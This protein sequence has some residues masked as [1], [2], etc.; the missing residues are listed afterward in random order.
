[1]QIRDIKVKVLKK[2]QN[3]VTIKLMSSNSR[4]VM[5]LNDFKERVKDGMYNVI[6][7]GQFQIDYTTA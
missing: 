1:M 5:R 2:N 4:M 3:R 7:K 6:N